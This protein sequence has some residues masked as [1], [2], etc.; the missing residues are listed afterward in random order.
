MKLNKSKLIETLKGLNNGKTTYQARKIAD[1]SVRR[2]YQIRQIYE[3]TGNIPEIR[4]AGRPTKMIEQ[5]EVNLV[6]ETYEKYRVSADTLEFNRILSSLLTGRQKF[7][8]K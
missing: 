6:K 3:L 8:L 5:W 7:F 4:K 1:I 2:V